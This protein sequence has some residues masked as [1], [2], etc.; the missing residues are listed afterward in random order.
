MESYSIQ[1]NSLAVVFWMLKVYISPKLKENLSWPIKPQTVIF[2]QSHCISQHRRL[3]KE[4]LE[5]KLY[6]DT[7][8]ALLKRHQ[9]LLTGRRH[10]LS[11]DRL[12]ISLLRI[13]NISSF[14][15]KAKQIFKQTWGLCSFC[16]A[17]KAWKSPSRAC[18]CRFT[19]TNKVNTI[20]YIFRKL[21]EIWL[22]GM[23]QQW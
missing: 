10:T 17:P 2:V 8:L 20:L 11:R 22:K 13:R 5:I 15:Q 9:Q 16:H 12:N 14:H 19:N 18:E 6:N 23:L 4:Q 1:W 3:E 21:W 7:R